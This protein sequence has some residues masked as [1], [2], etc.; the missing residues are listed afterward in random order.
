MMIHKLG[1]GTIINLTYV[2]I[3]NVQ[4][5]WK[6]DAKRDD[7]HQ[8]MVIFPQGGQVEIFNGTEKECQRAVHLIATGVDY[9]MKILGIRDDG[10]DAASDLVEAAAERW[11]ERNEGKTVHDSERFDEWWHKRNEG[12]EL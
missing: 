9:E 12:R 4:P 7:L 10:L 5:D 11:F 3:L 1:T 2:A 8:V 6:K